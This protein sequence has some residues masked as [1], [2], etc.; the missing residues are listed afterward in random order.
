[1]VLLWND[2][3]QMFTVDPVS[4][5]HLSIHVFKSTL[6]DS[7]ET[8][9]KYIIVYKVKSMGHEFILFF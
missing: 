6:N 8:F 4:T 5:E 2:Y 7:G 9:N 3:H 1:M